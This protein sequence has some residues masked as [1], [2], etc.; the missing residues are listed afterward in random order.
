MNGFAFGEFNRMFGESASRY[1]K[2]FANPLVLEYAEELLEG[3]PRH[4]TIGQTLT[5][6]DSSTTVFLKEGVDAL[7]VRRGREPHC[8]AQGGEEVANV[9]FKVGG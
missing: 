7:I 2:P 6:H 4:G 8:I 9:L 3:W 1:E 5:L